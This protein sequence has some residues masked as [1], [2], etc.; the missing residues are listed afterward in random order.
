MA[1]FNRNDWGLG[2]G[3]RGCSIAQR[4]EGEPREQLFKWY[5]DG[6]PE[7]PQVHHSSHIPMLLLIR[8]RH[9]G[10]VIACTSTFLV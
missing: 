6:E 9:A 2:V 10:F 1:G 4:K 5:D 7:K 3:R 8:L